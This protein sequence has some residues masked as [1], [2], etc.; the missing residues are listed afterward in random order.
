MREETFGPVLPVMAVDSLEEAVRL[1]NDSEYGLT[2]S[3]WT[4]DAETAR[5]LQR[6]LRAGVVTIN[7][8]ASSFGEPSAPWGGL[9]HSGVGRTHGRAGLREMVQVKYVARD[10]VAPPAALVVPLR[11]RAARASR[12][13]A[14]RALHGAGAGAR[15]ASLAPARAL[16]A[17]CGGGLRSGHGP[18]PRQALLVSVGVPGRS[19]RRVEAAEVAAHHDRRDADRR[20][21]WR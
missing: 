11:P 21:R 17:G 8:C 12:R 14:L 1:A 16:A 20:S 9:K 2:A 10:T 19:S 3:A 5:R 18:A 4:R 7:D 6:E 13:A 15:L